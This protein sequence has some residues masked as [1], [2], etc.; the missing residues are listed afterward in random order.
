MPSG[1]C[2]E[3]KECHSI[4]CGLRAWVSSCVTLLLPS[5]GL[6]RHVV[7]NAI[8]RALPPHT[9]IFR[10]FPLPCVQ[11]AVLGARSGDRTDKVL[12]VNQ[13]QAARVVGPI[14][15]DLVHS[16]CLCLLREPFGFYD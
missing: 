7:L 14:L 5:T 8:G 4:S 13:S 12:A 15:E 10:D 9:P 3:T 16:A 1:E 6:E 2:C 11:F